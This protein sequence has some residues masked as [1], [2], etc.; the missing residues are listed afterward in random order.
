MRIIVFF[1]IPVDSNEGK[2]EYRDFRKFLIEDGFIMLQYSVYTKLAMNPT[3]SNKIKERVR[4][5]KPIHGDVSMLELTEKQFG[6]I[7]I[8]CGSKI[9]NILN[10]L[11]RLTIFEEDIDER[12]D[13][14]SSN[15]W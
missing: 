13:D 11:D 1:D 9:S 12:D 3:I 2:K 10:T 6:N 15:T 7:E 4:N 5:N 8:I 14:N